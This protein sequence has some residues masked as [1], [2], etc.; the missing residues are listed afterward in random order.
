MGKWFDKIT[1]VFKSKKQEL[2]PEEYFEVLKSRKNSITVDALQE[3][4]ERNKHLL[5]QMIKAGQINAADRLMYHL[6][7]LKREQEVIEAGYNKYV[8]RDDI[9]FFIEKVSKKVVKIIDLESYERAIPDN[10][11]QEIEKA[12]P[13]FDQLYV[14]FT[15]Y[16][17]KEDRKVEL[18]E[19]AKDPIVFGA[20]YNRVYDSNE[21]FVKTVWNHRFYYIAD[22]IDEYCDLTLDK[23]VSMMNEVNHDSVH[24]A[25]PALSIED[26]EQ[27][28]EELKSKDDGK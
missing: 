27:R 19:R 20:F 14:V 3:L 26:L 21:R 23:F 28:L 4:F 7:N 17:G 10:V 5:D 8:F 2:H 11:V 25:L 16:T 13:M 12:K 15:D 9:D 6:K 1:S 24:V 22:W 18:A